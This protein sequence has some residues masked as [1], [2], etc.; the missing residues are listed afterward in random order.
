VRARERVE[1]AALHVE[2]VTHFRDQR[3]DG[4]RHD[5]QPSPRELVG[6]RQARRVDELVAHGQA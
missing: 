4:A 1:C 2:R 5:L 6:E 3:Q